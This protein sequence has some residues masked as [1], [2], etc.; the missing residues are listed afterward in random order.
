MAG[1]NSQYQNSLENEWI[2]S[3]PAEKDWRLLVDEKLDIS[4]QS[5][6]T[7]QKLNKLHADLLQK[8]C[9]HQVKG[10]DSALQVCPHKTPS[11]CCSWPPSMRQAWSYWRV[12]REGT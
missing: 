11:E 7:V 5:A 8:K 2:D 10:G 4:Q 9:D 1:S 3:S 6:P 12:Y